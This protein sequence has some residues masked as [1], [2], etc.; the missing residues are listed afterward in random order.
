MEE[1]K[2]DEPAVASNSGPGGATDF[3]DLNANAAAQ[4][5]S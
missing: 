5:S 1:L 4:P 2:S 3:E